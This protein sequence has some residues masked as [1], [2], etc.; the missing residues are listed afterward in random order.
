[1]GANGADFTLTFR[2]LSEA[3]SAPE[4]GAG[5][6]SLF[7]E[8]AAYDQWEARWRQRLAQEGTDTAAR[9][10]AMRA[11]NPAYIPRNHLVEAALSAATERG[12]YAPFET[13]L[14]V[15]AQ[16]FV[17]RPGLERFTLPPRPEE[18]VLATFCGT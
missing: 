1:M 13:L 2:R 9:R 16:P 11:V 8:P 3:A 4:G 6:R 18:R 7:E 10:A 14:D 12:D 5:V 17:E 15:L